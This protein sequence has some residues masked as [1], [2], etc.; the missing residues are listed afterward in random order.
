MTA[1]VMFY[2]IIAILVF[3]FLFDRWMEYLNKSKW[4]SDIP[5]ELE[6]IYD[7][8]KYKQQQLYRKA[9]YGF[10]WLG[11]VFS[12]VV[13][14]MVLAFGGFAW[15]NEWVIHMTDHLILQSL[16]FF[17]IIAVI[18]DIIQLPFGIYG[19]FVIEERFGFNK[20]TPKTFVLD[21]LKSLFLG[22]LIGGPVLAAIIWFYSQTGSAFW[23][24]AWALSSGF[25]I[26]MTM[27]YTSWIL[28][29]F[30]KQTPLE[31]G[32]LRSA[33]ETFSQKAGFKLE[34]VFVMDGSKRSTK[35]NA[36]F[37]GLG[38]RKRI[39]LYDTLISD[40]NTDEIV[41][42][43]AHEV[44][45]SKLKH[46]LW[47]TL[48]GLFQTGAM[49]FLFSLV[50][51]SPLLSG[52]LGVDEPNFHIGLLAFGLLYAPISFVTGLIMSVVSRKNEY[53]A[54]A[55]AVQFNLGDALVSGLKTM[56]VN[57]LSNLTP[58]P[59]YVFF[60]YSHPSLLQRVKA[61]KDLTDSQ[62]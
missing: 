61:I 57:A 43:L 13:I 25:M 29:L 56:S 21:H 15:L 5:A 27:F 38:S 37:S 32:E 7:P 31:A 58:H 9:N 39:V 18:S 48:T 51:N 30:N 36:F 16:L 34:N 46:T 1:H 24:Y 11:D 42:V 45:H 4:Q 10:S 14:L 40:L 22:A 6:G 26:L 62:Q 3:Q 17:A 19:T 59:W 44:G 23:I 49:L 41:A 8:E 12:L 52:A 53:A 35:G 28:P 54:D 47:G 50:V 60:H 55:Y 33:I 2:L 20:T